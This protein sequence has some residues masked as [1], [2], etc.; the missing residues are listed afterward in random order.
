[1]SVITMDR[2]VTLLRGRPAKQLARLA[3]VHPRTAARWQ[4]GE[5]MPGA[6]DLLRLMA[7]DAEIFGEVAR[8][9]G[10]ADEAARARAALLLD[11][12]MRELG[13]A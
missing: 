9:A 7:A 2:F 8:L 1:M 6:D 12:A 5:S 13:A 3:R 11:Q 10:R 4:A